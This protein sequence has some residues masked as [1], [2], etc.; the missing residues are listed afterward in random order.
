MFREAEKYCSFQAMRLFCK[1]KLGLE[2]QTDHHV[3][4][5][6][7][8]GKQC[9]RS[10]S[11]DSP[12]LTRVF[13]FLRKRHQ[14]QHDNADHASSSRA[15]ESV[16]LWNPALV[17]RVHR[18]DMMG[19]LSFNQITIHNRWPCK[20]LMRGSHGEN[21]SGRHVERR[22]HHNRGGVPY[23]QARKKK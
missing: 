11:A 21:E 6:R 20:Y 14:V 3:L 23:C 4:T 10:D 19:T 12:L 8:A 1:S 22:C 18:G 5:G 7:T 15:P 13:S 9:W 17:R 2:K 16:V